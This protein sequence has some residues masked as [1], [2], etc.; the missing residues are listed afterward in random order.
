[1]TTYDFNNANVLMGRRVRNFYS[2]NDAVT[3]YPTMTKGEIGY[4]LDSNRDP[5]HSWVMTG[6][7]TS[8]AHPGRD[9]MVPTALLTSGTDG[10]TVDSGTLTSGAALGDDIVYDVTSSNA[11]TITWNFQHPTNGQFSRP[12]KIAL[13]FTLT[14]SAT[15]DN[16]ADLLVCKFERSNGWKTGGGIRRDTGAWY[17]VGIR[18]GASQLGSTT[19]TDAHLTDL[20]RL[21]VDTI[22]AAGG[23]TQPL[24]MTETGPHESRT[25]EFDGYVVHHPSNVIW[26]VLDWGCL[27]DNAHPGTGGNATITLTHVMICSH[28]A[29]RTLA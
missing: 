13:R 16:A 12:V 24:S 22:P 8:L 27:L 18:D 19:F 21:S 25:S 4:I 14:T 23:G 3:A 6:T 7:G 26:G 10:F 11:P 1:M 15:M 28:I 9:W 29:Q 20:T 5:I 2:V 17:A